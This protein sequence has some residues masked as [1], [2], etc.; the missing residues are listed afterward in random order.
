MALELRPNC[1]CCDRDLP[2]DSHDAFICTFECTFCAACAKDVLQL[3]C[4]NCGGEL[5]RRP[6][7]PQAKLAKNPASTVRVRRQ[8]PCRAPAATP[9]R[10]PA[11]AAS[12]PAIETVSSSAALMELTG[13]IAL[14]QDAVNG[15]ASVGFVTPLSDATAEAY[16][17]GV[18]AE[19]AV[20]TRLLL[21]VRQHGRIAGS[22]QLALC[23]KPNG[24]HRAEVQKLLV[25]TTAR[26]Q[27]LGARLMSAVEAAAGQAGCSLLVLD[28]EPGRP[29]DT[30]Y[31]RLGWEVAGEI[32]DFATTPDGVAHPT[33]IFYKRLD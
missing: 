18:I 9:P 1:E 15:G 8:D 26:R 32:P 5:T 29:A 17:R 23:T 16:W 31:R 19:V 28:T 33:V 7:R 14:L 10:T 3:V 20:G 24:R 13:F 6:I 25:H 27:G 22:V 11:A 12:G 4:P 21:V 2:P 30:M